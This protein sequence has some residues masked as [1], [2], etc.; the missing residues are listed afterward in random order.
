M[1]PAANAQH[2]RLLVAQKGD[3]SLAIAD[4]AAGKVIERIAPFLGVRRRAELIPF[5]PAPITPDDAGEE[6]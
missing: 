5:D 6:R 1:V 4:P 3:H 2:A